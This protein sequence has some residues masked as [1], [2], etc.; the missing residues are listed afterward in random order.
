MKSSKK[1]FVNDNLMVAFG[2]MLIYLKGIIL[3]PV[4]IKSI[5]S[6]F[7]G[8]Y[9]LLI[10]GLGF[11]SG[12]STFGVGFKL[13]RFMP[14]AETAVERN[15]LFYP[16]LF[17]RLGSVFIIS[18][19]LIISSSFIKA[20][21]YEEGDFSMYIVALILVCYVL[22]SLSADFFRYTDR[23]NYFTVATTGQAYLTVFFIV[24]IIFV[25]REK[26]LNSLLLAYLFALIVIGAPLLVKV[27]KEIGF[28]HSTFS[29]RSFIEDMRLGFPLVLS[30]MVDF[31]LS[32]SDRYIIAAFMSA[33]AVGCY[34]PAYTLGSLVILFPRVFGVVLPPLL[35]RAYDSG[36]ND[37]VA[38]LVNYSIKFFF[39]IAIPFII[40]SLVLGKALL[41]LLA[42]KEVAA[43]A[44]L[45]VPIVAASIL[46]YGLNLIL[47]NML[48]VQLKTKVMFKINALSAI[49]NLLLN[50][51]FIYIFRN[52]LVAAITTLISYV[53]SF[54]IL[55]IKERQNLN[56]KYEYAVIIRAT[57]AS[58]F[59]GAVLY[60]LCFVLGSGIG[61]VFL[62]IL[63][64]IMA[65]IIFL[66][67]FKVFTKKELKFVRNYISGIIR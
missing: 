58:L 55:N 46:F 2:H 12:V 59:M 64:G 28:R 40:G 18:V 1:L 13:R 36:R 67:A 48:F 5:G 54:V 66:F 3:M 19:L 16:P 10:T 33:K 56:I 23:M 21:F 22:Y 44:W 39:L 65:Y 51:V 62:T 26:T 47:A 15:N 31:I 60:W 38:V 7:Y 41:E 29:V 8:N 61:A 37:E 45:A 34:S 4:L 32:G 25:F 17:F 35:S 20:V 11:I 63:A 49:L 30:Y 6:D 53:V 14:S 57:L 52:I 50:I 27:Y 9:I 24:V 42:N 43:V